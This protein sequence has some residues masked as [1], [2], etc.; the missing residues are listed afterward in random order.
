MQLGITLKYRL[1]IAILGFYLIS[2]L[3]I[4]SYSQV[5]SPK[6]QKNMSNPI[7]VAAAQVTPVFLN[8]QKTIEKACLTIEKA[9]KN[10]AK[11][12]VFSEVF[13]PGYPD[14]VWLIPNSKG[15]DLNRLFVKLVENSVTI[16]DNSTDQLCKAARENSINVVI[17][18]N[19]RN[20]ETSNSSLYNT[21]LYISENGKILGKHRKLIPTGGERLIWAQ[22][23]GSDL[24]SY[25]TKAGK[26]GGLI[27]WENYMPLARNAMYENGTQ[28]LAAPTWDKSQNWLTSMQH[29]AR[30]GGVFVISVCMAMAK[31][32]LPDEYDFKQLYPTDREWINQGNSCIIAPNGKVIAGPLE[33]EE[34]IIYADIDLDEIIAAKRMFDAVGH[35]SRPDVFHFK[36]KEK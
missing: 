21:I 10:G 23:D 11:L 31:D 16:P 29:I 17:G 19:E 9:A 34:G 15:A 4:E 13:I 22:G 24:K 30:E 26:V 32:D 33:A 35:Y 1:M 5:Q 12:V 28:I 20:A 8:K 36:V 25:K 6:N 27:C 14:W 18:M 2:F 7:K 3:Y